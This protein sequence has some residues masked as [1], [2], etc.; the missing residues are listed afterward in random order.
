MSKSLFVG[1]LNYQATE[2]DLMDLFS[3]YGAESCRIVEG[4][5]FGFVDVPDDKADEAISDLDGKD[6]MGR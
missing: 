4:R 5:G 6:F 2:A 3:K 1:N